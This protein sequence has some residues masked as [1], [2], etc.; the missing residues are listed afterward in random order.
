MLETTDGYFNIGVDA[1]RF[2]SA[3]R[4]L[5]WCAELYNSLKPALD[6]YRETATFSWQRRGPDDRGFFTHWREPSEELPIHLEGLIGDAIHNIRVT[7]DLLVSDLAVIRGMNRG[8]ASFPFGNTLEGLTEILENRKNKSRPFYKLGDEFKK[9]VFELKPY[10][11]GN[12]LLYAINKLDNIGKHRSIV[13]LELHAEIELS[14]MG[15]E[16]LSAGGPRLYLPYERILQ[17][18]RGE[19]QSISIQPNMVNFAL[20]KQTGRIAVGLKGYEPVERVNALSLIV[21]MILLT[22]RIRVSFEE[23]FGNA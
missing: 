22:N 2:P 12:D 4:K 6:A 3:A 16:L 13:G 21:D 15:A 14:V 23:T 18:L 7:L 5:E 9:L 17:P 8:L 10:D 11:G 1:D 20:W 19:T